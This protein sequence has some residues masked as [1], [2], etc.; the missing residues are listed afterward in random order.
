MSLWDPVTT[1]D[2]KLV[3]GFGE[4]EGLL[5]KRLARVLS[6]CQGQALH[7]GYLD[8]SNSLENHESR[9]TNLSFLSSVHT[10]RGMPENAT[11][12]KPCFL[13]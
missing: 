2:L 13:Q 11:S 4:I 12:A 8:V 10:I 5:K 6:S 9:E 1:M 7:R 3:S